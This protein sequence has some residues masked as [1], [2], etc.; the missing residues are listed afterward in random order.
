MVVPAQKTRRSVAT[1]GSR[2]RAGYLVGISL[3]F[4]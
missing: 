4:L 3:K 2:W 1:H